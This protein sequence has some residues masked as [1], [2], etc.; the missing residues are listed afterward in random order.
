MEFENTFNTWNNTGTE[1]S[2]DFIE[3]GFK[4][5]YKPPASVFNWFW[6]KVINALTEL[7][8]ILQNTSRVNG[9][10]VYKPDTSKF[11]SGNNVLWITVSDVESYEDLENVFLIV[12]TGIYTNTKDG[13]VHLNVNN[14]GNKV[15]RRMV[16]GL[17]ET[18]TMSAG[19]VTRHTL[20]L[21]YLAGGSVYWVNPQMPASNQI[22][23]H[24]FADSSIPG[25]VFKLSSSL[26]GIE[27]DF[28]EENGG[29]Q[30]GKY[31]GTFNMPKI[32]VFDGVYGSFELPPVTDL[33]FNGNAGTLGS[34]ESK[35]FYVFA[36]YSF[37][38]EYEISN[39]T[40]EKS[41]VATSIYV[42]EK[43]GIPI[44]YIMIDNQNAI[45]GIDICVEVFSITND[46]APDGTPSYTVYKQT[47]PNTYI[48]ALRKF[49]SAE[50][51]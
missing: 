41:N 23:R 14:L 22:Q 42:Q 13:P 17:D 18:H 6:A 27:F 5:G 31:Q 16:N 34:N 33:T 2:N 20:M 15:I 44:S 30:N 29:T 43:T 10:S 48:Y 37:D 51:K 40:I 45:T 4:A 21:L 35:T 46:I 39:G 32:S 25:T 28:E 12:D 7:Q 50:S 49:N 3:T 8:T 19:E 11:G 36:R 24:M 9:N 26:N 1:P 38:T 47:N